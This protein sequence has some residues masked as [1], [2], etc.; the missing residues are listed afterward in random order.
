[1]PKSKRLVLIESFPVKDIITF[2]LLFVAVMVF[3]FPAGELEDKLLKEKGVNTYLHVKYLR[4]LLKVKESPDL[5]EA[6]AKAYASVG[7]EKEALKTAEELK[8]FPGYGLRALRIKY[9][10][11]KY[12]FFRSK[13]D[14]RRRLLLQELHQILVALA[15]ETE[16]VNDLEELYRES[17]KMNAPRAAM[18]TSN[19]IFSKTGDIRWLKTAVRYALQLKEYSTALSLSRKLPRDNPEAALLRYRIYLAMR[20][21]ESAI[22]VLEPLVV[23]S[24]YYKRRYL[25]ELLSL[26]EKSQRDS[27]SLLLNVI[28]RTKDKEEKKRLITMAIK[29]YLG[30]EN[31]DYVKKLVGAYA[32]AFPEDID[33]TG[34]LLK[35]AL[36]T[37]DSMFAGSVAEEIGKSIG[38]INGSN[39]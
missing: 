30:R 24:K 3:L 19:R 39:S 31:Y 2:L 25:T 10:I 7:M 16:E 22:R 4:A 1:M 18:L 37:G 32:V 13:D 34:F 35:A 12:E 17:V 26:Y 8:K 38:V 20:D 6:L 21:Y 11:L 33:F 5:L 15:L 36:A 9:E 23:K 14:R 28:E 27:F 29:Y